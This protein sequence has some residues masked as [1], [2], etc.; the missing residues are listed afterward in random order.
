MT[1]KKK[2]GKTKRFVTVL[3]DITCLHCYS[4]FHPRKSTT[5]FCSR[6]CEVGSRVKIR[7][8]TQCGNT[9]SKK[10]NIKYCSRKC[11]ANVLSVLSSGSK[12]NRL[13]HDRNKLKKRGDRRTTAYKEWRKNIYIRD[14]FECKIN[15]SDCD[16]Q[17]EAHHILPW[18][19]HEDLRYDVNNGILL[20]HFHHPQKRIDVKLLSPYFIELIREQI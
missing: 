19:D 16:G 18:K 14:N 10:R 13:V 4:V 8:C 5:K 17:L 15:N 2:D 9:F 7:V 12:N 6:K 1:I 3:K 11:Y 20:C